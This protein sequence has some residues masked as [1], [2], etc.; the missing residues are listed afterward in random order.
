VK[1]P[2]FLGFLIWLGAT[3][4]LRLGGQYVLRD[5]ST[6]TAVLLLVVSLPLMVLVAWLVLRNMP[7]KLL[8]AI[9]LVVPGMLLDA[10]SAIWFSRV[11][12][13]IREDAAGLF[14]GW[15]LFCNMVV[16]VTGV[17]LQARRS[18]LKSPGLSR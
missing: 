7:D 4:G 5:T 2:A 8:A 15:L 10:V 1:L 3:V 14:G 16:L 6:R 11:F 18:H 9:A 12:P 13:N 17:A